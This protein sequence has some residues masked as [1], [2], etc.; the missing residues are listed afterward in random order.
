MVADD[1]V[2]DDELVDAELVDA[3]LVDAELVDPSALPDVGSAVPSPVVG[4]KLEVGG[5]ESPEVSPVWH[6]SA[7]SA[8]AAIAR[9]VMARR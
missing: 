8:R 3:E 1:A 5:V 9:D 6:A 7:I 4:V 2:D